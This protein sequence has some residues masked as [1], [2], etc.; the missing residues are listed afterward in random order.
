MFESLIPYR[1]TKRNK[2]VVI[3]IIGP[4]VNVIGDFREAH[5]HDPCPRMLD[6]PCPRPRYLPL[7]GRGCTHP[8]MW[9]FWRFFSLVLS[10]A[11][12]SR[13]ARRSRWRG[14]SSS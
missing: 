3:V 11:R 8:P 12:R 13:G 4:I 6:Y 2:Y 5:A 1:P 9:L 10:R 14:A 7:M